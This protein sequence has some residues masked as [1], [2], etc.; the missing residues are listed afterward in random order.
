MII[1]YILARLSI[2]KPFHRISPSVEVGLESTLLPF[3]NLAIYCS[4]EECKG[5]SLVL[6]SDDLL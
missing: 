1:T 2:L 3:G 6:V 4:F 5:H